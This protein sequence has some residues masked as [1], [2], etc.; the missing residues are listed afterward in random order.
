MKPGEVFLYGPGGNS[1]YLKKDGT[2]E[3]RGT[4]V[5]IDGELMINGV[6][7]TPCTCGTGG[8]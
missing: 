1:V 5:C 3:V 8:I 4:K 2:V 6:V 7:Y